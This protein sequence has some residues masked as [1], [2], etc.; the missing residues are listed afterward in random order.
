[1]EFEDL[2]NKICFAPS[3]LTTE[4]ITVKKSTS[5][6]ASFGTMGLKV[7]RTPQTL[8]PWLDLSKVHLPSNRSCLE[9]SQVST[10]YFFHKS[11]A[12]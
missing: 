3:S 10:F 6:R 8:Y 5:S 9:Y 7:I 11:L 12:P 2:V 4:W 1:V